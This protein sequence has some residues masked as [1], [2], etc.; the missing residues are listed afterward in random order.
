MGYFSIS[1]FMKSRHSVFTI[2]FFFVALAVS[3][4][5]GAQL[6]YV[7]LNKYDALVSDP[8][9]YV[10]LARDCFR[11]GTLY[12]NYSH[13]YS[14]YVFNPGWVNFIVLWL[15]VFGNTS[16]LVY[17]Q[18]VFNALSL[19]LIYLICRRLFNNRIIAYLAIF[20][21]MLI[22]SV[23][24]ISV[25]LFSEPFFIVLSLTSLYFCL[26]GNK[27]AYFSGLFLALAMWTR[28]IALGWLIACLFW[29]IIK[30]KD[31]KS[32]VRHIVMYG[33]TCLVIAIC[34]HQ[35]YPNY[36]YKSTT[37]GV[38]LIMGANDDA[39]GG[40]CPSVFQ[41][42]KMGYIPD[43]VLC[44]LTVNE[45][46]S[47]WTA[48]SLQWI[49]SHPSKYLLLSFKKL[50]ALYSH[51]ALF[52]YNYRKA[53]PSSNDHLIASY[54]FQSPA[55]ICSYLWLFKMIK[56]QATY[57]FKVIVMFFI[58]GLFLSIRNS[59]VFFICLPVILCTGM[60]ILTVGESRYNIIMLPLLSIVTAFVVET[61]F[62]KWKSWI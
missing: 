54:E 41:E 34:T 56:I 19:L 29:Y 38:N 2:Q 20:I 16:D 5:L 6:L 32:A 18:V 21:Y 24:T 37:G 46:D 33:I 25:H 62:S 48:R 28:P 22:P 58:I 52:L 55:T 51:S 43:S 30:Q 9:T 45:K 26:L 12:P 7:C 13:L 31:W 61:I 39:T 10:L 59:E 8:G 44:K 17:T 14:S 4:W 47:V 60:T 3:L 23:F 50:Y 53:P 42:G 27:Y 57:G 1:I 15:K 36:L 40:Y 49:F 35:N 11:D